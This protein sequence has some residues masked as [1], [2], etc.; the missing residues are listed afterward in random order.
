MGL[1]ASVFLVLFYNL[2]EIKL[3]FDF[4]RADSTLMILKLGSPEN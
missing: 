3:S 1:I 2:R 4:G